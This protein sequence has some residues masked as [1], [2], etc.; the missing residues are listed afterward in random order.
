MTVISE[1]MKKFSDYPVFTFR[2]VRLYLK[3]RK[4]STARI[5]S[6]MKSTGRIYRVIKGI[7]STRL[8]ERVSGFAFQPFY[9]GTLYALTIRELWTQNSRPEIITLKKVRS[10]STNIFE[11]KVNV[12]LHH[13]KPKY[14]FGFEMIKTGDMT[15]PVSDPEKTLIDLFF[16]KIRLP[17][18]EY[19]EILKIINAKKLMSYLKAY[20]KH[21][22][23]TVINFV[24]KYS[25]PAKLGKLESGY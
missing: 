16:Y 9:Y 6:H 23:T 19:S 24:K 13:S 12:V 17:I 10:S 11:D 3:G 2:D 7:Y 8:D 15:V 20:D 22:R 1:I 25:K 21:T 14:F 5:L 4:T 18:Q